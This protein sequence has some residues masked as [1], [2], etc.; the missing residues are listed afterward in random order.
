MYHYVYMLEFPDGMKYVGVH[1]TKIEPKLDTCYLGSGKALPAR[2]PQTCKKIILAE[3]SNR[4]DAVA[5]EIEFIENNDCVGSNEWYNLRRR[6]HDKHGS[7]LSPEH[8]ELIS[9]TQRGRCREAYGKKYS[10]EGRTPAQ[11]AG[12]ERAAEKVRGTKNPSKG[13]FGT[14]NEAF[15]P[16]YY[17][18]A[19]GNYV[20]IHDI[21]KKD[22]AVRLGVTPRQLAHRFHH[23]N[24]H[25]ARTV[26][27]PAPIKGWAFGNLPRPDMTEN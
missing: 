20:E 1:S 24:I 22:Y 3:F 19:E 14:E 21:P 6:T 4:E 18:D 12:A 7:N 11:R 15:V 10:G 23:S 26:K 9:Q 13:R 27:C 2:T 5:Y 17:I 16:W 8:R 25:W